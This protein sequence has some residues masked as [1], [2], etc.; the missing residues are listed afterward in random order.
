MTK[1]TITRIFDVATIAGAEAMSALNTLINYINPVIENFTRILNKGIGIND[2]L[3]ADIK[4]LSLS[5]NTPITFSTSKKPIAIFTVRQL[6]TTNPI[7]TFVWG[8]KSDTEVTVQASFSNNPKDK[9]DVT[10]LI[11]YS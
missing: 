10:L 4:V 7:L 8:F 6:P 2:N 1:L 9:T 11:F 3:D 5:N